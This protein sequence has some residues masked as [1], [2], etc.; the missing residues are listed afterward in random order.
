MSQ[1]QSNFAFNRMGIGGAGGRRSMVAGG[2]FDDSYKGNHFCVDSLVKPYKPPYPGSRS[3]ES[4]FS[5]SI[6]VFPGKTPDGQ[7]DVWRFGAGRA[8]IGNQIACFPAWRNGGNPAI[9]FFITW[10]GKRERR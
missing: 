6:R 8:D 4:V 3:R 10:F 2:T 9:T 1:G 7:F 5:C